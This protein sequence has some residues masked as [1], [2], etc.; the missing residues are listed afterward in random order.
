MSKKPEVEIYYCPGCK[1]LTRSSWMAQ[2][3]KTFGN[4]LASVAL[5]PSETSGTFK[6]NV[7]KQCVWERTLDGG[8]PQIKELK[9]RV[10]DMI[11]PERD[12]GY[13]DR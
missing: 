4:D 3:L 12:L 5:C 9:K 7:A 13:L 2:A 6:I 11:Q 10:R 1:W 8:F